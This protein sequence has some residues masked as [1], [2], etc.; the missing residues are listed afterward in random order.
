MQNAIVIQHPASTPSQLLLLFHG[1]G[2][3]A[4][5]LVPLGHALAETLPHAV[6][7]SVRSPDAGDMGGGW[8]W[9]SVRGVDEANRPARVAAAM[10]GF[11]HTVQHWQQH[12]GLGP[13]ATTLLG[14]SQGAI[15]ALESTQQ[16]TPLAQRVVALAGRFAQPPRLATPHTRVYLL[17]GEQDGVMPVRLAVAAHEQLGALGTQVTLDLFPGLGHGL[18]GRVLQRVQQHLQA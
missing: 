12:T 4:E 2:S 11:V 6:V 5:D 8:Q 13:Q 9:F 14:F 16:T 3:R 10:P 17:H 18:D 7:V 15:M 1:V